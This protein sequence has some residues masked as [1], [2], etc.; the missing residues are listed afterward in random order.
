M[1]NP[2]AISIVDCKDKFDAKLGNRRKDKF[3]INKSIVK[4]WTRKLLMNYNE[5][6]LDIW[7]IQIY[8]SHQISKRYFKS[9]KIEMRSNLR[10]WGC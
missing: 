1:W 4:P 9:K 3:F 2:G 6:L 10:I 5:F 7:N 8:K